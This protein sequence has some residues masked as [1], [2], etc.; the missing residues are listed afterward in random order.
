M[1]TMVT[2]QPERKM[3]LSGKCSWMNNA[4]QADN[5]YQYNG[6]AMNN[7]FGLNLYDYGARMYV[8]HHAMKTQ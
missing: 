2:G 6:K 4:T 7:D 8:M 3:F 1:A 5:R